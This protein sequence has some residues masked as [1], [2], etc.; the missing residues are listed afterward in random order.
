M[1]GGLA[2]VQAA[3]YSG[4]GHMAQVPGEQEISRVPSNVLIKS[5]N[6]G[7]NSVHLH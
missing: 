6:V 1:N 3:C 5:E 7:P 4:A 2:V